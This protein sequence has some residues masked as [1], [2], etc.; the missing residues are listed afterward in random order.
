MTYSVPTYFGRNFKEP[1]KFESINL[2]GAN[3]I[4][5]SRMASDLV[6]P[7]VLMVVL[8]A[9]NGVV[10]FYIHRAKKKQ[11]IEVRDEELGTF[12]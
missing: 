4:N 1:E 6:A 12:T 10:I 7:I 5:T 3:K 9:L 11:V 8:F 2:Q